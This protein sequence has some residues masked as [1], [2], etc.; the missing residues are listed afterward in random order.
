MKETTPLVQRIYLRFSDAGHG[1]MRLSASATPPRYDEPLLVLLSRGVMPLG[2]PFSVLLVNDPTQ[3]DALKGPAGLSAYEA[4]VDAG[5]KG[6]DAQW[7]AS[8]KGASA[9]GFLGKVAVVQK[10]TVAIVAG[11]RRV[12]LTIPAAWGIAAG[13][14]LM[15]APEQALPGYVLHDVAALSATSLSIGLTG[16]ALAIGAEFSI[17]CKLFRLNT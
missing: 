17:S 2:Q 14:P 7:M 3:S 5:F 9:G 16:P 12:L 6:T 15:I 8:L 11:P 10:A 1:M 13:D 4:A